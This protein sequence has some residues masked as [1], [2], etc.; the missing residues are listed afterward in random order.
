[1]RH[2]DSF[3]VK[4]PITFPLLISGLLV[5]QH[6]GICTN[7]NV[8]GSSPHLLDFNFGMYKSNHVTDLCIPDAEM[9]DGVPASDEVELGD[10]PTRHRSLIWKT[11]KK[12]SEFLEESIKLSTKTKSQVDNMLASLWP[13][14]SASITDKEDS[15]TDHDDQFSE[16]EDV[17][18]T[19]GET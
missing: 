9:N 6:S 18:D 11:L 13:L 17:G 1:M 2:F 7:K 10:I 3:S 15:S 19:H 5:S 4:L 12:A 14:I 16:H 8:A